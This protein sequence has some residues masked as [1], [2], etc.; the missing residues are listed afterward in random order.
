MFLLY[1]ISL[2]LISV[3]VLLN[4]SQLTE[5]VDDVLGIDLRETLSNPLASVADELDAFVGD[6]L[7]GLTGVEFSFN[8]G[9]ERNHF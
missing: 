1:F 5:F 7:S 8:Q 6:N 3:D 9:L 4:T 2:A